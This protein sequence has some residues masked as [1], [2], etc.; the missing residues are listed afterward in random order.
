VADGIVAVW[1]NGV[2]TYHGK[3]AT[4]Q[5]AGRFLPRNP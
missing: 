2:L 4:G 1:V 5:R 3:S